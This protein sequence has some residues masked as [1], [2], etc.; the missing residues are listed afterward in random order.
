MPARESLTDW[1][2]GELLA[3]PPAELDDLLDLAMRGDMLGVER[4]A[5]RLAEQDIRYRNFAGRLKELA[6]SFRT[7][8]VLALVKRCRGEEI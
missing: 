1:D 6:G 5:T 8:A 7:K 2:N 3:P 4:W